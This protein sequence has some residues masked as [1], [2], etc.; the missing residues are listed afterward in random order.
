MGLTVAVVALALLDRGMNL[1]QISLLYGF[2][3]LT[4][5][6]LELPFG[7][8]ADNIGRK[9]VFLT[10]VLASLLSLLLFLATSNFTVLAVS[11]ARCPWAGGPR[12][13]V[14]HL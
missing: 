2:Y 4:T 7:G 6:V 13:G 11:F 5:M 3:A 8:L 14:Q 12:T 9:P 10:A 1:F